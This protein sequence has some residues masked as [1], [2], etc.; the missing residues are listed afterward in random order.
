MQTDTQTD[1]HTDTH[2]DR[3]RSVQREV[4]VQNYQTCFASLASLDNNN[5]NSLQADFRPQLVF[6]CVDQ[7]ILIGVVSQ[8]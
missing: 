3:H 6:A 5:N 4:W 7:G 1:R 8:W 2:T